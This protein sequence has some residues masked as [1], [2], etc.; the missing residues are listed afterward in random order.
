MPSREAAAAGLSEATASVVP[1][2]A[3]ARVEGRARGPRRDP[4]CSTGA[5]MAEITARTARRRDLGGV[6]D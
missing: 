2:S 5:R 3:V 4:P 1:V 6:L